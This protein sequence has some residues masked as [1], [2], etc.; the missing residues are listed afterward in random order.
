MKKDFKLEDLTPEQ[1]GIVTDI[2]EAVPSI[3]NGTHTNISDR[4]FSITGGAGSGKSTT[5]SV[6]IEELLKTDFNIHLTATTHKALANIN[7]M[8]AGTD[9]TSGTIHSY[10]KCKLTENYT[11]GEHILKQVDSHKILPVDILFV[12][13]SSMCGSDLY[14]LIQATII[15]GRVRMCVFLGD[16]SQLLPVSGDPFPIYDDLVE[17]VTLPLTKVLRQ[18]LNSDILVVAT[19][20]RS[21]IDKKSFQPFNSIVDFI[22]TFKTSKDIEFYNTESEWFK[23]YE[24]GDANNSLITCF[25]NAAMNRYNT[26]ARQIA[27]GKTK[28]PHLM[29]N[30]NVVFLESHSI[31][32]KP[33]HQNNEEVTIIAAEEIYDEGNDLYYWKCVDDEGRGFKVLDKASNL[34]MQLKLKDIARRAKS[35]SGAVKTKLWTSYFF[36][37]KEFQSVSYPYSSTIHKSQGSTVKELYLDLDE[38]IEAARYVDLEMVYRLL[39]VAVTRASDKLIILSKN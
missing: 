14:E 39:Y 31:G 5:V 16:C 21:F 34:E 32:D 4:M 30:E 11:T 18:S 36:F 38:L 26:K 37:K 33:I 15:S 27:N 29:P 20:I 22:N 2:I 6:L 25:T 28:L 19:H 17:C 1:A 12:E 23:R 7:E 9:I 35:A 3:M 24:Q 8:I 13:E 10:L